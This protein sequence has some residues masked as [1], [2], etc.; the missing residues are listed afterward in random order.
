MTRESR[1]EERRTYRDIWSRSGRNIS[2]NWGEWLSFSETEASDA[3]CFV[4]GC[5]REV[6]GEPSMI[7]VAGSKWSSEGLR[8]RTDLKG[9]R[10]TWRTKE[11]KV[12]TTEG[13]ARE[14]MTSAT[15]SRRRDDGSKKAAFAMA[16]WAAASASSGSNAPTFAQTSANSE[17]RAYSGRAVVSFG[18][19]SFLEERTH[20][21]V[22]DGD[23]EQIPKDDGNLW[24][25]DLGRRRS[26]E[27]REIVDLNKRRL[28]VIWE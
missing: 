19:W 25:V 4:Q 20:S 27:A 28:R 13:D 23:G 11:R 3:T 26:E 6:D 22:S 14:R 24:A 8:A 7:W 17:R 9:V 10:F 21:V 15:M 12:P 16:S 1:K 5:W 18:S 2:A